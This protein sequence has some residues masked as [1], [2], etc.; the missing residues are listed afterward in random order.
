MGE[1]R[2]ELF[3]AVRVSRA[4]SDIVRQIKESI[5]VGK[6]TPGD[7]LP[8]ERELGE[9]FG[10]SRVTVR[11]ALRVL[12]SQGYLTIKVGAA[13]GAYIGDPRSTA[14]SEIFS[15]WLRLQ[16]A[17]PR[18]LVE[19]RQVIETSIVGLAARRRTARDIE[20]MRRI[21]ATART[22]RASGDSHF[23]PHSV[24]FHLALAR[25][26]KNQ[27]L[28]FT[29]QSFGALFYETLERLLPDDRMAA[30]AIDDHQKILDAIVAHDAT[31]AAALMR[32]HLSY[33]DRRTRK[34]AAEGRH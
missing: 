2:S 4:S 7:R 20:A 26:A 1:R 32:D 27:V 18:E 31:N 5:I 12:E 9:Q 24:N 13:G 15:D 28:L 8:S 17:S 19:A 10:L 14:P 16:R 29:V 21:V 11:D 34:A 6:L 22:E 3:Q 25:A 30:R 23:T 33:F